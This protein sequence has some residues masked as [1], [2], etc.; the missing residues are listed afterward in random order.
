M[1]TKD[2]IIAAEDTP[3]EVVDVPEWG[4]EVRIRTMNG[5]ERDSFDYALLGRKEGERIDIRGLKAKLLALTLVNGDGSRLFT[6]AEGDLLQAKSSKV[7]DDLFQ[8]S[9]R[10][11]GLSQEA[12][13][14]MVGNS[15]GDQSGDSGSG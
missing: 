3:T 7:L 12:V 1:L 9:Q 6:E 5:G 10:L 13:E 8:V 15:P 2:E 14:E 11:N 4:G